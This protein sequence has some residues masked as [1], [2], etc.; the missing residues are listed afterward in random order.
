M[1]KAKFCFQVTTDFFK[2]NQ[3]FFIEFII[4]SKKAKYPIFQS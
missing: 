1:F 3:D 2:K 4:A